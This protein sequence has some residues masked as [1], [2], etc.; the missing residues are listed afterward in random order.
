MNVEQIATALGGA[1]KD[2]SGW[3]GLCPVHDDQKPSLKLD[4]VDGKLLWNCRAGCSQDA[5]RDALASRGLLN[6][7][8]RDA[9]PSVASKRP[10]VP[11][12]KP[13][14][15]ASAPSMVDPKLGKP[16]AT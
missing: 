3:V 4:E 16:G 13:P 6:G 2:G 11:V 8:A 14:K 5:V 1:R 9:A 10:A 12:G 15:D 7:Y